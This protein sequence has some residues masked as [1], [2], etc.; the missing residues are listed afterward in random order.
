[1][2]RNYL[3]V[4]LIL[5]L[6]VM[7]ACAQH[8]KA[9]TRNSLSVTYR[10]LYQY[11]EE[12]KNKSEAYCILDISDNTSHFYNKNFERGQDIT[13]SMLQKGCSPYEIRS[14]KKQEGLTGLSDNTNVFKNYPSKGKI[15]VSEKVMEMFVYE[16]EMPKFNWELGKR[17][18]VILGHRCYE[19]FTRYR[20]RTWKVFYAI[21][22]PID[23]GPWKLCG[24]PGLILSAQDS[25]GCFSYECVGLESSIQR[26]LAVR[27]QKYQKCNAKELSEMIS[28]QGKNFD[29]MFFRVSGAKIEHFDSN[30]KPIKLNMSLTPCLKEI[31]K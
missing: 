29:E 2:K 26:P 11:C 28:L 24:L 1:M 7:I 9:H 12:N 21:D 10:Y 20:G 19:A 17:D 22:I 13:D 15:T 5:M 4:L 18:T 14:V 8:D 6:H 23:D 16:E 27:S 31:L 3:F 25:Q 30:G